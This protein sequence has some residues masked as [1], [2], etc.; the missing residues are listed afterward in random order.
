MDCLTS[1]WV[2]TNYCSAPLKR[3]VNKKLSTMKAHDWHIFMQQLLPLCLCGLMDQ[4]TRIA[5]TCLSCNFRCICAKV[6]NPNN[7]DTLWND[8]AITM[9]MLEMTMPP[10][11]F[12]IMTHLVLHLMEEL[13]TAGLVHTRWMYYVECLNKVLKGYIW[14]MA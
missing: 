12:D 13:D 7:M 11:L 5:I 8:V 14:N 2:P 4:R 6:L 1:L 3:V 10:V 9:C